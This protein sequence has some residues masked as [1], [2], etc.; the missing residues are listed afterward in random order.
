[1]AVANFGKA[2]FSVVITIKFAP[3]TAAVQL[4]AWMKLIFR[5]HPNEKWT[6][7]N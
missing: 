4:V 3:S 5:G 2:W 1:M 6:K 7:A